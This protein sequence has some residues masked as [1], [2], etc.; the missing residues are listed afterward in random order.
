MVKMMALIFYLYIYSYHS[1]YILVLKRNALV[2]DGDE[3]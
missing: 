2:V 3:I 1:L